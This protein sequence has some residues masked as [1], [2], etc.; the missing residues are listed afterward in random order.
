MPKPVRELLRLVHVEQIDI[1]RLKREDFEVVEFLKAEDPELFKTLRK[2]GE[3]QAQEACLSGSRPRSRG[4]GAAL[5][6]GFNTT[7]GCKCRSEAVATDS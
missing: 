2:V 7:P 6:A 4:L 5:R 3:K 1:Q